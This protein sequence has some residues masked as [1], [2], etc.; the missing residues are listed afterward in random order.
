MARRCLVGVS[1]GFFWLVTLVALV[2]VSAESAMPEGHPTPWS[3][4]SVV[5]PV[6]IAVLLTWRA[7]VLAK[8]A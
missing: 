8:Q 6:A 2:G 4:L 1:A 5:I 7:Y 3:V